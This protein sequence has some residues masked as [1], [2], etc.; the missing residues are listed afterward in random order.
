MCCLRK[1]I[2]PRR[3]VERGTEKR[4]EGEGEWGADGGEERETGR[5]REREVG[6]IQ[7]EQ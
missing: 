6:K 3:R 7:E 4:R 5:G 2:K 1:D